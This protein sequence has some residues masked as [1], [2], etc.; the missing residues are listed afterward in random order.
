[1][2]LTNPT[3][4]AGGVV[5]VFAESNG[6]K[7]GRVVLTGAIG[8]S[9]STLNV[10][11]KGKADSKGTYIKLTLKQGTV[12]ANLSVLYKLV[13]SASPTFSAATCSVYFAATSPV[14]LVVGT[15]A[16]HGVTGSVTLT[17]TVAAVLPRYASGKNKGQCDVSAN[18]TGEQVLVTGSG[19]IAFS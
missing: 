19:T 17:F 3:S 18:P 14:P 4:R 8:D 16:Y 1:M 9:G 5:N 2:G 7:P 10:N 15:G 13:D 11:A 12:E 6:S